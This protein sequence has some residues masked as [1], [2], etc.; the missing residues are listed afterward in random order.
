VQAEP[1]QTLITNQARRNLKGLIARRRDLG[2][3]MR[4]TVVDH[5][6]HDV[7]P[8]VILDLEHDG[9]RYGLW[10]G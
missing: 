10:L 5:E 6:Q 8:V 2:E 1:D 7:R 9:P 3:S 4:S